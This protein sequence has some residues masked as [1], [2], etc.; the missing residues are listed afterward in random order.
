MDLSTNFFR[1]I[2]DHIIIIQIL[3][4]NY[5]GIGHCKKFYLSQEVVKYL[6]LICTFI[7]KY[8]KYCSET[9]SNQNRK[10]YFGAQILGT[11]F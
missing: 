11:T 10:K 2:N 1:Y 3:V 8:C 6:K 7:E 5:G 9:N 4:L